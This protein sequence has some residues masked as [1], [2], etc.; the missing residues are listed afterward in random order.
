MIR[1]FSALLLVA[2][3]SAALARCPGK[4]SGHGVCSLGDKCTC[5]PRWVGPDCNSRQ[6]P[7]GVSWVSSASEDTQNGPSGPL[8]L[9]AEGTLT[10]ISTTTA[11]VIEVRHHCGAADCTSLT[12]KYIEFMQVGVALTDSTTNGGAVWSPQYKISA[13]A[14][15]AGPPIVETLT[16]ATADQAYLVGGKYRIRHKDGEGGLTGT[17]E[18]TECSSKGACDRSTG[19]CTC[20]DGYEGR[21]CRR[22][23]CPGN[24]SGHGR[25]AENSQVNPMYARTTEHPNEFVSQY[26]DAAMTRQ[27]LCDR[28]WEGYDCSSRMCPTGD[29][30]LT[31]CDANETNT[32]INEI[33]LL[34]FA[35]ITGG[36]FIT[37]TFQD[38]FN[39]NYTTKP[40]EI[41]SADIDNNRLGTALAIE[42]ALEE[43]PNFATPNVTVT[44]TGSNSAHK[45]RVTFVDEAN[46]GR[47]HLLRCSGGTNAKTT[48]N[49]PNVQPRFTELQVGAN[50]DGV[51]CKATR[52]TLMAP[53]TGDGYSERSN[54]VCSNR[55]ICDGASGTCA[56]FEGFSGEACA[57]QT[58][59][60]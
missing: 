1:L 14:H 41:V 19:E 53:Y 35:T 52:D 7:F 2:S 55:G 57:Q 10:A 59:F 23:A 28:G 49:N 13:V 40:I 51:A 25:C 17:R 8:D 54:E 21:G 30:P 43:L 9:I 20:Y 12:N 47:Q 50:L 15:A 44:H 3:F 58:V 11:A 39:G 18:Y 46:A 31:A 36:G 34:S 56:C 5:Q 26:W 24:C 60:F 29:D 42:Q 4:C 27:C 37:L 22:Q 16:Y 6:C 32:E 38:M 45:Y 48:Y 33:Q